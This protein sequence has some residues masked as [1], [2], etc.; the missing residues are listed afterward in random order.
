MHDLDQLLGGGRACLGVCARA[1]HVLAHVILDHLRDEPVQGAAA[2]GRLLQDRRAFI[3]CVH[4]AFDRLELPSHALHA[5]Q[6]FG[7]LSR[8]M[9]HPADSLQ[10]IPW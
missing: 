4:G 9:P 10:T 5:V 1:H 6:Q 8:Y 7:L 2:R 3:V